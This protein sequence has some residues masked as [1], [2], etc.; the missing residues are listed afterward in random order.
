[1]TSHRIRPLPSARAVLPWRLPA[2]ALSVATLAAITT[3]WPAR[4]AAAEGAVE[5]V[6]VR[7]VAHFDFDRTTIRGADRDAILAEVGKMK[8]VTWQTVTATGHTDAI[9]SPDYNRRLAARRAEAVKAYLVDK[10]LGPSM[11]RTEAKAAEMPVAPNDSGSG[12]AKNRRAEIE[13]RGVR[14]AAQ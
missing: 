9:G 14:A 11:I 2:A 12:R 13:F 10:G 5:P 6:S 7:A 4:V 1:M 8:G 3:L